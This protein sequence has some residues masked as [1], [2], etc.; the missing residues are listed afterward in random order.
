MASRLVVLALAAAATLTAVVCVPGSRAAV[1]A[2]SCPP[3]AQAQLRSIVGLSAS[4]QMRNTVDDSGEAVVYLCNGVAWSGVEPTSFQGAV[5]K[6][7][8]GQ[9]AGFGIQVWHPNSASSDVQRWKDTDYDKLTGE[10]DVAAETWPGVF[11]PKGWPSSTVHPARLG[12]QSNGLLVRPQGVAKGLVAAV[13]CWWND[14]S[15]SAVCL[16]VEEEAGKPV[17]THL[18]QLAKIV[19]PKVL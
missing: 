12:F 2:G 15:Y 7:R 5:Q 10:F 13:G 18:N 11:T 8:S 16:F 6:A 4:L 3:V 19:V 9:G 1:T 17:L 14:S